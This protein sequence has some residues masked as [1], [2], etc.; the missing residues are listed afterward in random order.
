MFKKIEEETRRLAA[1]EVGDCNPNDAELILDVI[2][3]N[4]MQGSQVAFDQ[5]LDLCE[6]MDS[7]KDIIQACFDAKISITKHRSEVHDK[8]SS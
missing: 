2:Q 5:I 3:D 8:H 1:K 6:K 7:V 4:M